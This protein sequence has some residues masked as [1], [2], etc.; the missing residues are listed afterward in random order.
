MIAIDWGTTHLRAYR[1]T[2][3]GEIDA[4]KATTK[5]IMAVSSGGFAAVL[6]E[7][8]ADWPEQIGEPILMSGMV[9]SRHGWL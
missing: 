9:G 1:L 7:V 8:L 5:G 6:D 3:S 4:R 2:A